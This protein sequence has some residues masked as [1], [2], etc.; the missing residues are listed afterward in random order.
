[1]HSGPAMDR[2]MK[3]LLGKTETDEIG[4]QLFTHAMKKK[5]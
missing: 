1:M 5:N 3:R 4:S 2:E